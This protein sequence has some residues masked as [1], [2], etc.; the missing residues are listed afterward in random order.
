MNEF[1][2]SNTL[3][4]LYKSRETM[5]K[6]LEDRNYSITRKDHISFKEF[7]NLHGKVIIDDV[8]ENMTMSFEKK[9]NMSFEKVKIEKQNSKKIM[10][11]WPTPPKLGTN[12][13]DICK[14]MEEN[15]AT[16]SIII[17]DN[18]VTPF[19]K[20]IIKNLRIKKIYIDVYTMKESQ[21]DITR[22]I[23]VPK[24]EICSKKEK[25][26]LLKTYSIS[27][28]QIPHI[29]TAD[30]MVRHLG[31]LKGDLIRITRDSDTQIGYECITYRLVS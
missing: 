14:E 31:A 20:A 7:E 5:L 18:S 10:I 22:H 9:E 3:K 16:N 21:F 6:I 19:T 26:N 15:N 1:I 30:P 13:R 23:D 2:D 12:I 8:K 25:K 29:R 11:F 4:V 17:I 27:S 28:E 24:H